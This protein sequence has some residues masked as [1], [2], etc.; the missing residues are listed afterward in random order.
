[1]YNQLKQGSEDV[2]NS[3]QEKMK[4]QKYP[5]YKQLLFDYDTSR[6][7]VIPQIS[8]IGSQY[9]ND[10]LNSSITQAKSITNF[11]KEK[12]RDP[13]W[14]IGELSENRFL[15][16]Q[17]MPVVCSKYLHTGSDVKMKRQ[18]TRDAPIVN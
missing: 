5:N 2:L 4:S 12:P 11:E 18:T 13:N 1:M 14:L 6:K 10:Y 15:N 17:L 16:S 8:Y 9:V 7:N 3:S